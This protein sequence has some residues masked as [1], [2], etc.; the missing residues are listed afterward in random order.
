MSD[1]TILSPQ[2]IFDTSVAGYLNELRLLA[3]I[4][5]SDDIAQLLPLFT[6]YENFLARGR[7][8]QF[9]QD[10]AQQLKGEDDTIVAGRVPTSGRQLFNCANLAAACE[11]FNGWTIEAG[12]ITEASPAQFLK[13]NMRLSGMGQEQLGKIMAVRLNRGDAVRTAQIIKLMGLLPAAAGHYEQLALGASMARRDR[14]GFHR[15]PGIGPEIPGGDFSGTARLNFA[16][17]NCEPASLVII[18]NDPKLEQDFLRINHTEG[19]TVQAFNLDLYDGL[20]ELATTIGAGNCVPRNLITLFRL[21]PRAIP[22][23][24]RFLDKL[25]EVIAEGAF[26]VATIGSGNTRSEFVARTAVFDEMTAALRSRGMRP[27]RIVMHG[28]ER[29]PNGQASP[30][31]GI[32]EFASFEILFCQLGAVPGTRSEQQSS[33]ATATKKVRDL[34]PEL[35]NSFLPSNRM[36][37][38]QGVVTF[39][40]RQERLRGQSVRVLNLGSGVGVTSSCLGKAYAVFSITDIDQVPYRSGVMHE[41]YVQ[42]DVASLPLRDHSYDAL[43]SSYTFSYMGNSKEVMKEWLR[44]LR[45]GGDAWFIFHAPHSAYLTTSKEMLAAEMSQDFFKLLPHF[46]G[47]G[48][49]GLYDWYC[50][51]NPAWKMAFAEP[52]E[53]LSY[54]HEIQ[55][56]RHLVDEVASQMFDSAGQIGEFF[57]EL[58]ATDISVHVLDEEFNVRPSAWSSQE[59]FLAWFVVLTKPGGP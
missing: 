16:V 20:E 41:R 54:A 55:V 50:Q 43:F 57:S 22:D 6:D 52:Q 23:I 33:S 18:D 40:E 30:D 45:P 59:P 26:L 27:L 11:I 12:A 37:L 1:N 58:D 24:P 44:V 9:P 13:E 34:N 7:V 38:A 31:F 32:S 2:E 47:P 21:E 14:E 15:I 53:F 8:R 35:W 48:F 5:G 19:P 29:Q 4:L 51:Q 3:H 28:Q 46:P 56:C 36:E 10:L 17:K 42:A 49:T 39:L 25:E